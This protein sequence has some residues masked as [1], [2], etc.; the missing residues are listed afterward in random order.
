[1]K[2]LS[3]KTRVTIWYAFFLVLLVSLIFISL[4][5]T[6]D[7]LIQENI[8]GDL[9]A[10]VDD[11]I[12]DVK[13]ENGSLEI[14]DDLLSYRDGIYVLVYR[15]NN[16]IVTGSLPTGIT[17]EI[18]FISD[19][20]RIVENNER[21]YYVYDHLISDDTFADVW[22]RGITSADLA[23]SDPAVALMLKFFFISLP[24][25]ILVAAVGG[26]Y[27]TKRAF[28]P[29]SQIT[30]TAVH[31]QESSDLS[32]R[33]H[34]ET[35]GQTKDEI[36]HLAATFDRMLDRLEN[37]F[38]A[39]KQFSNDA[40]HEL[41]TPIAVIM[42]QCEYSLKRDT[43]PEEIHSSLS[44]ILDQSRK[45]S[46]LIN[47][48]LTLARADRGTAKLDFERINVSDITCMV[49]LEQ[50][51]LA[52]KRGITIHQEITPDL[53]ADVDETLF[54]RLWINLISNSIK[55][56]K[57]GG[58]IR[59]VLRASESR[60]IGQVIDDGI[61]ISPEALPKIWDRFYQVNPS[62]S[63]GSSSGLG[64]SMVKWIISA[65]NGDITADSVPG[66]GSR[67]TFSIPKDA[68]V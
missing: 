23:D 20:V 32:Q 42:A 63:D 65:H 56:G 53:Y 2:K 34:L 36:Y 49:A 17:E 60:I 16:F 19:Q 28:R 24:L 30:E 67:F 13:I 27:I 9:T 6:S 68:N 14:D 29:V 4:F 55:Y 39:E 8:K 46:T 61:G 10:A 26:Y 18:P 44:V 5:Y 22:I 25:L 35:G 21:E 1:M 7:R 3:I 50:E 40:S 51:A 45:M 15:E 58:S 52:E 41:R 47:Q 11:S 66:T 54:M 37:S 43:S 33:I 64:L 38:E 62:R 31:I 12:Q 48:L 57:E 59:V